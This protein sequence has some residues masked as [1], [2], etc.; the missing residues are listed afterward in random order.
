MCENVYVQVSVV[1][2]SVCERA[3]VRTRFIEY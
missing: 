1:C 2:V 3:S